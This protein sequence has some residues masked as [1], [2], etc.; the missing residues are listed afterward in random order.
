MPPFWDFDELDG[1]HIEAVLAHV[2]GNKTKP[3]EILGV[4]RVSL[5]RKLKRY[6][7]GE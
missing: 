2:G 3:T 1:R 7:L 4:D 5:W 6:G